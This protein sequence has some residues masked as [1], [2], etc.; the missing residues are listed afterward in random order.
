MPSRLESIAPEIEAQLGSLSLAQRTSLALQVATWTIEQNCAENSELMVAV[1]SGNKA[2]AESVSNSF[3]EN[4]FATQEINPVES[5][6][7]FC[8]AR[9]ASSLAFALANNLSEAIYEAIIAT[10][11]ISAVQ[12]LVNK[13]VS[14][15]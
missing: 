14:G 9:A 4:Y 8:C 6:R 12:Q 13:G 15:G 7:N 3:D 5:L 2:L 10:D 1:A 11:D